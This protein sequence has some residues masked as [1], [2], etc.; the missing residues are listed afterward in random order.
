MNRLVARWFGFLLIATGVLGFLMPS[1][2]SG[3]PAYNVFHILSGLLAVRAS[4]ASRGWVFNSI[5]GAIDVYQ[6]AAQWWG[7]WP[8]GLFLWTRADLW[9]HLALGPL[10]LLIGL[11]A[12]RS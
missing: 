3:A 9:L 5:F 8:G 7:W 4:R 12:A 1:I 2:T 11:A 10:L 6:A